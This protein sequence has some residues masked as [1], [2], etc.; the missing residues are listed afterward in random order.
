MSGEAETWD[1]QGLEAARKDSALKAPGTRP[2]HCRDSDF[3]PRVGAQLRH[4]PRPRLPEPT[5]VHPADG[6]VLSSQVSS[7]GWSVGNEVRHL[8]DRGVGVRARTG[9]LGKRVATPYTGRGR[10]TGPPPRA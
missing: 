3:R 4:T 7:G 6:G 10:R 1:H 2:C 8:G 9:G 5:L